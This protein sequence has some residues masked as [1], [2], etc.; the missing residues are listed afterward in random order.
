MAHRPQQF[1]LVDAVGFGWQ[2]GEDSTFWDVE[3]KK[4]GGYFAYR[5]GSPA[6]A[7]ERMLQH[8]TCQIFGTYCKDLIAMLKDPHAWRSFAIKL[9]AIKTFQICF[10]YFQ[11]SQIPKAHNKILTF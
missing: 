2:F 8:S 5:S 6:M 9:E 11:I 10:S 1:S 3:L 4:A 7:M